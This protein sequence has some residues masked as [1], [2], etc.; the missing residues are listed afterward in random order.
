MIFRTV[1]VAIELLLFLNVSAW[2]CDG[3]DCAK[4]P[5]VKPT[6]IRQFMREQAASTTGVLLRA[7]TKLKSKRRVA[8]PHTP[9]K[10]VHSTHRVTTRSYSWHG[11]RRVAVKRIGH[12]PVEPPAQLIAS[13]ALVEAA[14]FAP[15]VPLVEVAPAA[16]LVQLAPSAHQVITEAFDA[17]DR[18]EGVLNSLHAADE[19]KV[20][21][22]SPPSFL[23]RIWS[24][25]SGTVTTF[26][27]AG[28]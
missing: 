3:R 26:S 23:Q 16:T 21:H 14:S 11:A 13:E 12:H 27:T 17:I 1:L 9:S 24:A 19:P 4:P 2:A 10:S 7:A 28:R 22:D 25:L 20:D 5:R 8:N 6:Q 15:E 18:N